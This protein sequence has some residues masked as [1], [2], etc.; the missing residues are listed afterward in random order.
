M[1]SATLR[2]RMLRDELNESSACGK[3][4]EA[5][6]AC[7]GRSGSWAQAVHVYD[8]L[9]APRSPWLGGHMDNFFSSP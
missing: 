6:T 2:K 1:C 7:G 8:I 9:R 5:I 3:R 4:S